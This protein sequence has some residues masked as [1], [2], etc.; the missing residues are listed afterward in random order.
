VIVKV[1]NLELDSVEV[2]FRFTTDHNLGDVVYNQPFWAKRL[3][4]GNGGTQGVL[5]P[6]APSVTYSKFVNVKDYFPGPDVLDNPGFTSSTANGSMVQNKL[7]FQVYARDPQSMNNAVTLEIN[8]TLVF[9]PVFFLNKTAVD[10]GVVDTTP[11][12]EDYNNSYP[13]GDTENEYGNP[14]P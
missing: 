2:Y 5:G 14:P 6:V 13:I 7:Y 8:V 12:E 10:T 4:R 1:I 9:Y 3:L 11:Y